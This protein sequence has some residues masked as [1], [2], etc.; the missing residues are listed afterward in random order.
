MTMHIT[1]PTGAVAEMETE[2]VRAWQGLYSVTPR[3][4]REAVSVVV[5]EGAETLTEEFYDRMQ[6]N[7]RTTG[8][9]DQ[10]RVQQRLRASLRR[11]M[12]ELFATLD[13]E[14]LVPR[15]VGRSKWASCTP[16]SACPSI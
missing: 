5:K 3:H 2:A 16:A 13:D 9:L 14:Q 11:W 8:F 12:T 6:K 4:V 1:E 10:E 7:P 15:S